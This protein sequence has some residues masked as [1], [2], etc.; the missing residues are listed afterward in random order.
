M[1]T[2]YAISIFFLLIALCCFFVPPIVYSSKNRAAEK[3][4]ERAPEHIIEKIE[5]GD[6]STVF[7]VKKKYKGL[8]GAEYMS[9]SCDFSD[10]RSAENYA[11]KKTIVRSEI[12][13]A[14]P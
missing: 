12:I 14:N 6:G 8:T 5:Y 11:A 1:N 10:I 7:V 13:G 2:Y 9:I 3:R 4:F